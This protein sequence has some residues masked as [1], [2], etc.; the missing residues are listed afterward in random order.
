M[1]LQLFVNF[2]ATAKIIKLKWT[3]SHDHQPIQTA[4]ARTFHQES[5]NGKPPNRRTASVIFHSNELEVSEHVWRMC[6]GSA[7]TAPDGLLASA[8]QAAQATIPERAGL[9]HF[10][11]ALPQT[12]A[13]STKQSL[14]SCLP[15]KNLKM[16]EFLIPH[17]P[18][19]PASLV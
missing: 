3:T 1:T 13:C 18:T 2:S 19:H 17:P 16:A 6:F 12:A 7:G 10:P 4:S 9:F 11:P 5:R 15:W 14:L 8:E